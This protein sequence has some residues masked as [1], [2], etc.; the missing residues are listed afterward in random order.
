MVALKDVNLDFF[1]GLPENGC[2]VHELATSTLTRIP[3]SRMPPADEKFGLIRILKR[4][5][6]NLDFR[7]AMAFFDSWNFTIDLGGK[8]ENDT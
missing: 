4:P 8:I 6:A 5:F 2:L 7:R 1:F 3:E